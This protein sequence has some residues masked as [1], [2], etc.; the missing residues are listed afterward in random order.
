MPPSRR[1]A[2]PQLK[3]AKIDVARY[4]ELA[5]EFNIDTS[6]SSSQLPTVI[7]FTGGKEDRRLPAFKDGQV[8]KTLLDKVG[9]VHVVTAWC[10]LTV[11]FSQPSIIAIFDLDRKQ[12]ANSKKKS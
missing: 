9:K 10:S 7:L 3:F 2:T 4:Q 1:Y 5:D 8:V 12:N 11:F 6:G